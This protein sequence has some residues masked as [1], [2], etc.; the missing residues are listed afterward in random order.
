M[1]R[2]V[3]AL[4][5]QEWGGRYGKSCSAVCRGSWGQVT[6]QTGGD[7]SCPGGEEGLG[8]LPG[9]DP[10]GDE[11]AQVFGPVRM[12]KIKKKSP[13]KTQGTEEFTQGAHAGTEGAR[14]PEIMQKQNLLLLPVPKTHHFRPQQHYLCAPTPSVPVWGLRLPL[15]STQAVPSP[16]CPSTAPKLSPAPKKAASPLFL[17]R[18]VTVLVS[19]NSFTSFPTSPSGPPNFALHIP[20]GQAHAPSHSTIPILT[21]TEPSPIAAR[22]PSIHS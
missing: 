15:H 2:A 14:L 11:Y 5:G 22:S 21:L 7:A 16:I 12:T 18:R 17:H 1:S 19:P 10:Q 13:A 8:R 6:G 20:E 9:G 3:P 4:Q